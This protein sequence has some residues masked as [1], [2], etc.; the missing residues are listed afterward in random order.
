MA[1]AQRETYHSG[2]GAMDQGKDMASEAANKAK[3]AG[4]SIMQKAGDAASFVG[5]KAE[6]A[7]SFVGK[8]AEDATSSVGSGM[9]SLAGTIRE[10][11]TDKGPLGAA[12][13]AVAS[14]LESGGRY[15]QEH[16][17]GGIGGDMANLIKRNP[18][19]ALFVGI[20]LGFLLARA[21]SSRS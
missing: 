6:D 12:G 5:K 21:T 17:L 9:K 3:D 18:I 11:V 14:T 10:N 13:S 7:A 20:G 16:G 1:T 19:P 2:T 15:L 4:S 8:K